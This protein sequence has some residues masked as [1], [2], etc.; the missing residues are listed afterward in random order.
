MEARPGARLDRYQTSQPGNTEG[1]TVPSKDTASPVPGVAAGPDTPERRLLA[2]MR[3]HAITAVH[4]QDGLHERLL[5]EAARFPAVDCTRIGA[6][7]ALMSRLHER[8]R[9][10]R[11]PY[12]CHPLRVTIRILAH[13]RVTDPDVACAALLHD[14]VEDHA[15]DIAAGGGRETA[16]VVLGG[17]FGDRTAGLVAA[18]TNPAWEAGRDKHQQYLQHVTASLEASPWARVI[19]VSDFTDNAVGLPYTTGAKL[20]ALARKYLPL[21]ASLR[22]LILRRDT[23]LDA[24]VKDMV[25]RQLDSAQERLTAICG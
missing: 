21:V 8:D 18:V 19:K 1:E 20:P 22:E 16:L 3:L 13:Y 12:A 10:Q 11:E 7:L 14:A 25:A 6:A 5:I 24:D 9:R 23:P 17:R 2:T 15:G 4:G